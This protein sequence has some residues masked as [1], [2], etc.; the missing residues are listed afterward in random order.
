MKLYKRHNVINYIKNICTT[1]QKL[2]SI[3]FKLINQS[4]NWSVKF[5]KLKMINDRIY[6]SLTSQ[7]ILE[8]MN[9]FS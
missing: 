2:N 8:L 7:L 6:K 9:F 5:N 4:E 3:K 1:Y